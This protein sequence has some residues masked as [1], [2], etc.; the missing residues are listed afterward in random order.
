MRATSLGQHRVE[1]GGEFFA[2]VDSLEELYRVWRRLKSQAEGD[3]LVDRVVEL[4]KPLVGAAGIAA[5]GGDLAAL[6]R[7]FAGF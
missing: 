5:V 6:V 4:E 2:R 1:V 3:Q 7:V